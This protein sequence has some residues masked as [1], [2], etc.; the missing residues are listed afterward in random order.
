M[1]NLTIIVSKRFWASQQKL[2]KKAERQPN[3]KIK[4]LGEVR[5]EDP[6]Q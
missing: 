3:E 6:F 1:K 4:Q 5:Q 2:E